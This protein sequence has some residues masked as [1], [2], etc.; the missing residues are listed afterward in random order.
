[1]TSI[2]LISADLSYDYVEP[3]DKLYITATF[4]HIGEGRIPF[5]ASV[6]ADI[7]FCGRQRRET[8]EAEG[9]GFSWEP[10]PSTL[11]WRERDV[12]ST[13]GTW[14]VP[15]TW[16]GSFAVSLSLKDE[17]GRSI[18][19]I[20]KNGETTFSQKIAEL[21][22][23]WG[24]GRNR[25][26][27][28]R[29]PVSVQFHEMENKTEKEQN[30]TGT[31]FGDFLLH[32]E[33][34]AFLGYKEERWE[35]FAPVVTTRCI[36]DN[37]KQ[38]YVGNQNMSYH[39]EQRSEDELLYHA[40]SEMCSFSLCMQKRGDM[41]TLLLTEVAEK[42]GYELIDIELPCL[43]QLC[44]ESGTMVNYFG[45]G[46]KLQLKNALPQ[47][48]LFYYDTCNA[49]GT[50]SQ[51]GSFAVV[52]NDVDNVLIQAVVRKDEGA[53]Q[54]IIGVKL[55]NRICAG[56]AGMKSIPVQMLPL[57]IHCSSQ[58][59]W[60]LTADVLR[61]KMPDKPVKMYENVLMYKIR[62]DAS[63]Q[64]HPSNPAT[65][66][67]I[68]TLSDAREIIMQIYHLS[69]GMKQVVYL[70]GWQQGGHDFEYPYPHVTGF[71]KKC[72]TLEEFRQLCE[73]CRKYNVELSLHDNFD[74]AYLSEHYEINSDILAIDEQ[75]QE[76]KGWLWAGG[77]SYIISP[78]AYVKSDDMKE[79]IQ[80]LISDY[81]ISGTYHLDVLSSEVRR[82]SFAEELSC[83]QQNI[84]AKKEIIRRFNQLG[85]DITSETLALPFI[86]EIGYAQ[87]TRYKFD[88]ELFV[89]ERIVPL[90]TVAFHGVTPYKVGANEEKRALL[91]AIACGA[92]CSLEVEG[93]PEMVLDTKN[94]CR[95][96]YLVSVPMSAFAYKKVTDVQLEDN[97]WI[98][99]YGKGNEITVDFENE[100]YKIV[101]DGAVVSENFTTF[102]QIGPDKYCYYS[103][104]D[105]M[106]KLELPEDWEKVRVS[107]ILA[108]GNKDEIELKREDSLCIFK[109]FGDVPYI[110]QKM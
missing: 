84:D 62:L 97:R 91:Q 31:T 34:P 8:V 22:I 21:D 92:A 101:R 75:G 10:F 30:V 25:L 27:E 42:E 50:C 55:Q 51:H 6:V 107:S 104:S 52:A 9:F 12:W 41:L 7:R 64:Y 76:W 99:E 47:S 106:A 67:P 58:D 98:L 2:K 35:D 1:M 57:E 3:G 65:Y 68:L 37:T 13:T 15:Q 96:I 70:V 32:S 26:L 80:A 72:G 85:I 17:E 87:N 44:D 11:V 24:W 74:D 36:S 20:G 66:S 105:T 90:T 33:Y 86:G 77:M 81:G 5:R 49:L 19:F 56:R 48:A 73:E 39:L 18:S 16:G 95:N 60:K 108:N 61:D 79:R 78:T 93:N 14:E 40:K 110:I 63:G 29:K 100:S 71:N 43:I 38:V 89:G 46:R 94:I 83:A 82:Y 69:Q 45:G 4:Q 53:N 88:R 59:N 109:A 28:Q 23:G 54:G 102:A 103:V